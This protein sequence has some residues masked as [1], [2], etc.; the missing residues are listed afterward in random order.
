M[1]ASRFEVARAVADAV[2]ALPQVARLT[3]G[4]LHG[5]GVEVATLIPGGRVVGVLGDADAVRVQIVAARLPLQPVIAAVTAAAAEVLRRYADDR[6]VEVF[7]ADVS[8]E[9]LRALIAP[10]PVEV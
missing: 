10:V 4:G 6:P 2:A 5:H 9:A 3:A 7:V 1:T 8:D